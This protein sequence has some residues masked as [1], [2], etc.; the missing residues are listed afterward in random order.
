[1]APDRGHFHH[2]LIDMGLSQKQAVAILY[3]ISFVLGLSAVIITTDGEIKALILTFA[4]CVAVAVAATVMKGFSREKV[5]E[6]E[7][8]TPRPDEG[9]ADSGDE[10]PPDNDGK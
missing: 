8:E 4:F 7:E 6:S 3:S 5:E 10:M 9:A 1:M 2:R